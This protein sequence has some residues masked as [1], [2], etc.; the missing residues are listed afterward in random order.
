MSRNMKPL[1]KMGQPAQDRGLE[2]SCAEGTGLPISDLLITRA[3][4]QDARKRLHD[5]VFVLLLLSYPLFWNGM[6]LC[7]SAVWRNRSVKCILGNCTPPPAHPPQGGLLSLYHDMLPHH[8]PK[9]SDP[10]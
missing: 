1:P 2:G 5:F 3:H 7:I 8:R 10:N 4:A 9:T 6:V